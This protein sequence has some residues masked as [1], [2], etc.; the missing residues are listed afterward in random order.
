MILLTSCK[1]DNNDPDTISDID[2][3]VYHTVTIGTQ[4]W[5]KENLKTTR[6]NNG[7]VISLETADANW[8]ALI[9]PGYCW[10]N[11]D[12]AA[13]GKTYGALYNYAAVTSGKL[14]P[15]GW[16]IPSFDEWATL[17]DF[18]GGEDEAGGSLKET[19]ISHWNSPN[20][21][22]TDEV[23]FTALPSGERYEDGGFNYLGINNNFWTTTIGPGT[24][25]YGVRLYNNSTIFHMSEFHKGRGLSVRC[26]KD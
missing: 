25:P 11:N 23:G 22:A 6:L 26:I 21:G 12:E 2:G 15:T 4:V 24:D 18:V 9:S 20:T 16:H 13:T 5:L 3:N 8:E 7:T 1:K 10:Y 14:C 19:G 17:R